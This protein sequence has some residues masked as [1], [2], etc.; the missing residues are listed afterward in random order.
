MTLYNARNAE[1]RR[2]LVRRDGPLNVVSICRRCAVRYPQFTST[3][4]KFIDEEE[5]SV[6]LLPLDWNILSNGHR[7][8][9]RNLHPR[10]WRGYTQRLLHR[11][12]GERTLLWVL[13][14]LL[15]MVL[16]TVLRM[17]GVAILLVMRRRMRLV[18]ST[19]LVVLMLVLWG[20]VL[21]V[22]RV[23]LLWV[24][25]PVVV[26]RV[27]RVLGMLRLLVHPVLPVLPRKVDWRKSVLMLLLTL[28]RRVRVQGRQQRLGEW[29]RW[30]EDTAEGGREG[31]CRR[32]WGWPRDVWWGRAGGVGRGG[33]G[34]V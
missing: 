5:R 2:D 16:L 23:G 32:G 25:V 15:M 17:L 10:L 30:W 21:R 29:A 26:L 18:A 7:H 1:K 34:C 20:M 24:R 22:L 6:C 11:V 14:V 3:T 33:A 4:R 28:V 27:L 31:E 19:R 13:R 9:Q 12:I 8:I